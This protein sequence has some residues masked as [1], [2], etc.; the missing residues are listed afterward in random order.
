M[1][2]V[3]SDFDPSQRYFGRDTTDSCLSCVVGRISHSGVSIGRFRTTGVWLDGESDAPA[4]LMWV[5][6]E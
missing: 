1:L 3:P 2:R 4:V 6:V 5:V